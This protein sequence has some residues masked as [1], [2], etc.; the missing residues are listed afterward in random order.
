MKSRSDPWTKSLF[1]TDIW[2]FQII[3]KLY[4][5]PAR[6]TKTMHTVDKLKEWFKKKLTKPQPLPP[7]EPPPELVEQ[8][9]RY[10]RLL[11]AN[12]AILA[13]LADPELIPAGCRKM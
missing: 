5:F 7:P 12:N 6:L 4:Y 8:Y 10:K 3:K 13:V 2:I 1:L 9:H 11:A